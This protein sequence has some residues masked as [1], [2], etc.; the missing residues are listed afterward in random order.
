[1]T[2][3]H[4]RRDRSSTERSQ[5]IA[6]L[7]QELARVVEEAEARLA[8]VRRELAERRQQEAQHAE[9]DRLEEHLANATVQWREVGEFFEE[10]LQQL[11]GDREDAGAEPSTPADDLGTGSPA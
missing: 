6:A 5:D 3:S 10:A 4:D 1:M 9:I 2:A 8:E 11:R 7:E